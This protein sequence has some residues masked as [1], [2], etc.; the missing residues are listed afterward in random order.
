MTK[1]FDQ[2]RQS[3]KDLRKAWLLAPKNN[4]AGR[5]TKKC[6]TLPITSK[7]TSQAWRAPPIITA[8]SMEDCTMTSLLRLE[9]R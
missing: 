5:P 4:E 6:R 1:M 9:H 8:Q 3:Y 2:S 7:M